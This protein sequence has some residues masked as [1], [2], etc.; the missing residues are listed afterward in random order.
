MKCAWSKRKF[1]I[2]DPTQ[3]IF[4]W[5][6]LGFC[7]GGNT[8]L[9]F[10]VGSN[11]NFM[12]RIG[13]NENFR[14]FR[15]QHVGKGNAKSSRWGCYSMPDPNAKGLASQWNIG[16]THDAIWLNRY[17]RIHVW[18]SQRLCKTFPIASP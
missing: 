1:C 18:G 3:P 16:F 9:M 14:V 10:C 15:Y 11:E 17:D 12:F 2:G 5:L 4:Y 7:V 8:S 6:A 13:G